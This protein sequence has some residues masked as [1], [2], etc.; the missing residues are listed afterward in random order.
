MNQTSPTTGFGSIILLLAFGCVFG[1]ISVLPLVPAF[2][3]L[4][5]EEAHV[6]SVSKENFLST[7][8]SLKTTGGRKV[9]CTHS[10]TGGCPPEKMKSLLKE[11]ASVVVW[12]DGKKVYQLSAVEGM[13]LPY[14]NFHR[15][16]WFGLGISATSFVVAF[17]QIGMRKGIIGQTF[18]PQKPP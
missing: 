8:T 12:H 11:K 1:L 4:M 15:G 5:K 6:Q 14:E 7:T 3:S 9:V 13:V 18:T 2:D 17:I 16:R 10:K